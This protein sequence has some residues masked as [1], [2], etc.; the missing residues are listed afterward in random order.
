MGVRMPRCS[1][2]IHAMH[3]FAIRLYQLDLVL[4]A[5]EARFRSPDRAL[6]Q[7]IQHWC[8]I[9]IGFEAVSG[10]IRPFFFRKCVSRVWKSERTVLADDARDVINVTMS[11]QNNIDA[12]GRD[13]GTKKIGLQIAE[14]PKLRSQNLAE[15][16]VHEN[17]FA[18]GVYYKHVAREL[19][20]ELQIACLEHG[21]YGSLGLV[22]GEGWPEGDRSVAVGYDSRLEVADLKSIKAGALQVCCAYIFRRCGLR[23]E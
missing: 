19:V 22:R 5:G 23:H 8:A 12:F 17:F 1:N 3:D 16:S 6:L 11:S 18:A 14:M 21:Q 9:R 20:D 2:Q 4:D 10:P 13:A 7:D 15:A